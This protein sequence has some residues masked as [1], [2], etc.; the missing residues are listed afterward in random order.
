MNNDQFRRLLFNNTNQNAA[1]KTNPPSKPE[2]PS[3]SLGSK[4]RSSIPMT[5]YAV[6]HPQSKRGEET[7]KLSRTVTGPSPDFA[8]QLADHRR[9]T[10]QHQPPAKK[11]KSSAAP[12]GTKLPGGYQDRALQRQ[13]FDHDAGAD[14]KHGDGDGEEGRDGDI[15]ERVKALEEMVKLGQIER[16]TFER[17]MRELGVGGDVGSTHMVKGL[18]WELLR[19]VKA[20]ED[21]SG[22][23]RGEGEGEAE[24]EAKGEGEVDVDEEFEKALEEKGLDVAAA[25]KEKKEKKGT[26][27]PPPPPATAQ[28]RSRNEI[29]RQLKASR[30]GSTDATE[31]RPAEPTPTPALG[32]KF[33]KFGGEETKAQK[34]RF[35]DADENG[36]RR[37]VLLITD[38]EGNTKRKV[39][40][41]D[42]PGEANGKPSGPPGL[43]VPDKDAEP[44]GMEVPE[45][46]KSATPPEEKDDDIFE[47]V[48][49]DYNPLGDIGDE[50]STD[51]GE[52]GEID[53]QPVARAEKTLEKAPAQEPATE[54]SKPRNYFSTSAVEPTGAE[55]GD[56]SNPLLKDPTLMAAF[57]RAATLRQGS[58]AEGE[59][60]E[61]SSQE[62]AHHRKNFL[63][64]IRRRDAQ[65]AMDMDMGFGGSRIEDE[66]DEEGPVFEERG[67]NKRK[68]GP[69]KRKGDKES[70]SDVMRVVEGRKK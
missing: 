41:L 68:R 59:D 1:S 55:P 10:E 7:N 12:K 54:P 27:A 32:T 34:K 37:E 18:D 3:S 60:E 26:M 5:P 53:E 15:E 28:K 69:K 20:G 8:R 49:A 67:G 30:T 24:A 25:P 64:E 19:K 70:A 66:E 52:D 31:S 29:L 39:K 47:G 16:D 45:F 50:T 42:K 40:W 23:S 48:G 6:P 2:T 43:L 17:L 21:V 56:R 36:R 46:A 22:V 9:E 33:K 44:L 62:A 11:F 65:D 35:V 13:A 4:T 51:S 58:P 14:D 57:K 38:A 61:G 63:E